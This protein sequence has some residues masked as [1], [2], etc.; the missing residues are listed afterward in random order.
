MPT[1]LPST[2]IVTHVVTDAVAAQVTAVILVYNRAASVRRVVEMV[3]AQTLR[4]GR[5]IVVDNA[6]PDGSGATVAA[7]HPDVEV[8]VL[9]E[10]RGVGAGH[11]AGWRAA[12]ADPACEFIWAMEHDSYPEPACL[13]ELLT[14]YARLSPTT[15]GAP[16]V[17]TPAQDNVFVNSPRPHWILRHARMR[18]LTPHPR[19]DP[20]YGTRSFSFNGNLVPVALA[21]TVG[22]LDEGFFFYCEDTDYALRCQQNGAKLYSVPAARVEHNVFAD[23]MQLNLGRWVLLMPGRVSVGRVY[24]GFRN[25]L[26]M[27]LR[28]HNHQWTVYARYA[29]IYLALQGFDLFFGVH[30]GQRL[31]ARTLALRDGL[32]GRMGR[33]DYR[34][35]HD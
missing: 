31:R 13:A 28:Q 30:R 7:A 8:I 29:L 2:D 10:N 25:G 24:Y 20:P 1:S 5:I 21:R 9:P 27:A 6:S 17:V 11:N 32:T 16:L 22:G 15:G 19:V 12:M 34:I 4:P 26:V 3:K 14:T 18:R 33:A 35:L 23:S